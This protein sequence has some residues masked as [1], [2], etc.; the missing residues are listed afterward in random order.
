[1]DMFKA[2]KHAMHE[3]IPRNILGYNPT[4][5]K[6]FKDQK[7]LHFWFKYVF[8]IAIIK[9]LKFL[10][11]KQLREIPKGRAY[12]NYRVFND[13]MDK[14]LHVWCDFI[15]GRPTLN[16]ENHEEDIERLMKSSSVRLV[17]D[18]AEIFTLY[19]LHDNAYFNLLCSDRI[20]Y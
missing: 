3:K 8:L 20:N 7:R 4:W 17:Q 11:R 18:M 15:I 9:S 6:Y 13:A 10:L 1:M 12:E 14:A 16:Q 19:T 2:P 5:K